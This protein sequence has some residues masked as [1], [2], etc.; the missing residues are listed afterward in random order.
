MALNSLWKFVFKNSVNSPFVADDVV[1]VYWDD[2]SL[3]FV[4]KLNGSQIYS[5]P[6]LGEPKSRDRRNPTINYTIYQEPADQPKTQYCEVTD[7][8]TFPYILS[9][10][11]A[12]KSIDYDS[13]LCYVTGIVCDVAFQ[14]V[15][16]IVKPTTLTSTDGQITVLATTSNGTIRYSLQ[17]EDYGD[18]TNTTGVFTGLAVGTYNVYAKDNYGCRDTLIV[19]L[20]YQVSYG[21]LY[22]IEYDKFNGDVGVI[23]IEERDYAGAVEEVKGSDTPFVVRLRGEESDLFTSVLSTECTIGLTSESNFK[24]LDL[25]TQ[26]DRKYRVIAYTN[27]TE[28]WRGF[29][30]PGLY[31]EQYYTDTNYYVSA[32]AT[33]QLVTLQDLQFVDKD[34]NKIK[35]V[36]SLI[37]IISFILAKTDL[38]LPIRSCVN[39]WETDM[40][41]TSSDDPLDQTHID[42]DS[43]YSEDGT[44]FVML[45]VLRSILDSFGSR[46]FQW[47]GY[48]YIIPLD[49][50][51][52]TIQYRDFDVNGDY[53]TNG[54][55][56]PVLDIKVS[57]E[58]S[59]ACWANRNQ[60]LEV[61]KA[62]GK[63]DVIH[64]LIKPKQFVEN[65]G[66]EKYKV[67][68]K[69]RTGSINDWLNHVGSFDAWS[70]VLNGNLGNYV[71]TVPSRDY[72]DEPYPIAHRQNDGYACTIYSDSSNTT[73]KSDVYIVSKEAN[74]VY[75]K[76][77]AINF[78]FDFNTSRTN[79]RGYINPPIV[80][81][82][83]SV[84]LGT[85]YL[86]GD[87]SWTTDTDFE[88]V[89]VIVEEGDFN[90]WKTID[91]TANCPDISG[92]LLTTYQ[93][94][95][96]HGKTPYGRTW[97]YTTNAGLKATATVDLPLNYINFINDGSNLRWYKLTAGTKATSGDN[98]IRPDDYAVS[99]NEVYWTLFQTNTYYVP[100]SSVASF[101]TVT[102]ASFDNVYLELLPQQVQSPDEYKSTT[103]NDVNIKDNNTVTVFT[104]DAPGITNSIYLYK[105]W[106]R[107]SNGNPTI[108]WNREGVS[109]A[110]PL[111]QLLSKRIIELHNLPKF[112]LTGTLKTDTFFGFRNSLYEASSSKYFVPMSM[113]INDLR[114]EYDVELQ[115]VGEL[116]STGISDIGQFD[117]LAFTTAFNI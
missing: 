49:F 35:G 52:T 68:S 12:F 100:N 91:I 15:S 64:K 54:T 104:G 6:D 53:V 83:W 80:K 25:F 62:F 112:K 96:M 17:D 9:F 43:F 75:T 98:I 34:G 63:C 28:Y 108:E 8:I 44:P 103:E 14:G 38:D 39:I 113:S 94:K 107:Y 73:E 114:C 87:G 77:D 82:K 13:P 58:S 18:M 45:D 69:P 106:Y 16:E 84:K 99:T 46:L 37:K 40:N 86:Q 31:Q 65:G 4:T 89:E 90:T 105:N 42:T 1:I 48:W 92:E 102:V 26:D 27:G 5:G 20:S 71:F 23:D 61:R 50:Y 95:L 41:Q 93:V 101:N 57:T 74:I 10:P 60:N 81:F 79:Y 70:L 117:S 88:W 51:T 109:E 33:D 3:D 56:D 110:E 24:F 30:K 2:T 32:D 59:R 11:Y 21:P 97:Y 115:E 36:N 7:L 85:Y 116:T 111:L 76:S 29:I 66:F 22:R 72:D 55:F 67:D 19:T 78:K 47:G